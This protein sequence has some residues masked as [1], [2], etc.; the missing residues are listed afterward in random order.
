MNEKKNK[1]MKT[2]KIKKERAE[3]RVCTYLGEM[4]FEDVDQFVNLGALITS[5]SE[6][7]R[8]VMQD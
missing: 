2:K 1:I 4:N 3:F 6:E 5:K 7:V 8:K